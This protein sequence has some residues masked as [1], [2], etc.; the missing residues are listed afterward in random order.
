MNPLHSFLAGYSMK[1]VGMLD[2]PYVRRTAITLR[3]LG[4]P[5]EHQSLSVFSTFQEFRVLN[6]V[7]KAPTLI[8]DTGEVLMDSTLI[9]EYAESCVAGRSLLPVDRHARML[10]LQCISHALVAMDKSVQLIYERNLRPVEAQH[11]PW[12]QRV[13]GQ[14]LAACGGLENILAQHSLSIESG[15]LTQAA[16]TSAVA[17]QFINNMLPAL[18]TA[19][20]HPHL[21]QL[22]TMA[23]KLPEFLAFPP[24]GPGVPAAY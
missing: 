9:I 15:K 22:S 21:Q 23:E 12:L 7:V 13:T 4:V 17:W 5:L 3:C 2:S 8:L 16:V 14:V 11:E 1:L 18:V 20:N 6:P 10:E 19:A 24:D